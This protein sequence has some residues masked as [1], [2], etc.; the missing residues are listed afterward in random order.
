[1]EIRLLVA[2]GKHAGRFI[3]ITAKKFL[4]GR[5]EDCQLRPH[6]DQVSRH[7]CGILLD[8]DCVLARDLGSKNGTFV[9]GERIRGSKELKN[10]DH[11]RIGELEFEIRI[12]SPA[13]EKKPSQVAAVREPARPVKLPASL[14]PVPVLP[15][16]LDLAVLMGEETSQL[17]SD[18]ETQTVQLSRSPLAKP[19][20]PPAATPPPPAPKAAPKAAKPAEPD[21]RAAG[22]PKTHKPGQLSTQ[23]AAASLLKNFFK[24]S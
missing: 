1:M 22:L 16:D 17:L 7:H 5:A 9:N 23:E 14:A 2:T 13:V 24:R 12:S 15:E 18:A 19:G 11:V 6:S 21:K 10:G 4:I 3:P 20:A 8:G